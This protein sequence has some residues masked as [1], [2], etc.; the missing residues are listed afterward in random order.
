M[1]ID[2]AM[3]EKR[4]QKEQQRRKG[5]ALRRTRQ[6]A[7]ERTEAKAAQQE[8]EEAL[9]KREEE[10]IIEKERMEKQLERQLLEGGGIVWTVDLRIVEAEGEDDKVLL[11]Q[12]ALE[13]LSAKGAL[14]ADAALAFRLQRLRDAEE[15]P[16]HITHC[17]VREFTAEEGT[18][19]LPIKVRRSLLHATQP[20]LLRRDS[21]AMEWENAAEDGPASAVGD[22]ANI[23][24]DDAAEVIGE[25]IR[26][27]FVKLLKASAVRLSPIGRYA[28][29][30]IP[31]VKAALEF[32]FHFHTTVT[33]GDIMQVWHRG[34]AYDI[35]VSDV[36]PHFACSLLD[37]DVD[38]EIDEFIPEEQKI[39]AAPAF[40]DPVAG[41]QPTPA[42]ASAAALPKQGQEEKVTAFQG[43]GRSLREE[44]PQATPEP[45]PQK[46]AKVVQELPPEPPVDDPLAV[47]IRIR[48]Q[49]PRKNL[50]RRFRMSDSLAGVF[51]YI[52]S[53]ADAANPVLVR[54]YPKTRFTMAES[55]RTLEELSFSKREA[56][57]V[58]AA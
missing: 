35:K 57:I 38:V 55:D 17:G 18:I 45:R 36:Q 33:I 49:E 27:R 39:P 58:E 28:L 32:N 8:I 31:D 24:L 54:Q 46:V 14:A 1:D 41:Q 10:R 11:P 47:Q 3:R 7:Q 25:T 37:T 29:Q 53:N 12:S 40:G 5:A 48:I 22:D 44:A 20:S 4:L 21:D 56:F 16:E 13:A 26:V 50:S 42:P 30:A 51:A 23:V 52:Q 6:R 43:Q 34:R 19:G 2:F 9:K 15:L